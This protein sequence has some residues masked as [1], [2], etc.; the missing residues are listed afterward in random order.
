[1]NLISQFFENKTGSVTVETSIV[2]PVMLVFTISAFEI[3]YGL[4]QW[5]TAQKSARVGARLAATTEPVSEQLLTITGLE[6]GGEPGDPMPEY[7]YLCDGASESC[8]I[9]KFNERAFREILYGPD[10]DNVC[11]DTTKARRGICDIFADVGPENFL[12][13]YRSSGLGRAGNPAAPAPL[14][15]ITLKDLEYDLPLLRFITPSRLRT[16]PPV[17]VTVVAEDMQS[18]A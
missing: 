2:L 13:E 10:N 15:T 4:F 16:M 1:M 3:S 11:R 14:I 8:S 12:I 7:T 18:G 17:S 5:N 6:N 9:G